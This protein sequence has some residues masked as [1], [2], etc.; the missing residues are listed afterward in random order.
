MTAGLYPALSL[1][2]WELRE[3]K[4]TASTTDAL[5]RVACRESAAREAAAIGSRDTWG[6]YMGDAR[7][8]ATTLAGKQAA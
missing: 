4:R 1:W 5:W 3:G 2:R 8:L 7:Q 6:H